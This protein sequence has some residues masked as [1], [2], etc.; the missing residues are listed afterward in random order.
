MRE[1]LEAIDGNDDD[2]IEEISTSSCRR[3]INAVA[4]GTTYSLLAGLGGAVFGAG[5]GAV[6]GAVGGALLETFPDEGSPEV[7]VGDITA[8][9]ALGNTLVFGAAVTALTAIDLLSSGRFFQPDSRC[10]RQT[11]NQLFGWLYLGL[12]F[13]GGMTGDV[14]LDS[15]LKD[16]QVSGSATLVGA[17]LTTVPLALL[18]CICACCVIACVKGRNEQQHEENQAL[19]V[20]NIFH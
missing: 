18:F 16:P 9:S 19:Q 6:N 5:M 17:V 4:K 15:G 10:A 1:D 20:N 13:F 11:R 2:T 14:I 12:M 8:R 3:R 7:N